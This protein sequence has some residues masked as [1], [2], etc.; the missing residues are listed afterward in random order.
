MENGL[1]SDSSPNLC[2]VSALELVLSKICHAGIFPRLAH[3]RVIFSFSANITSGK[4]RERSDSLLGS[5]ADSKGSFL[6]FMSAFVS[7]CVHPDDQSM[8]SSSSLLSHYDDQISSEPAYSI[9][10][11]VNIGKMISMVKLEHEVR[12]KYVAS[13]KRWAYVAANCFLLRDEGND[14]IIAH[15]FMLDVDDDLRQYEDLKHS[16]SYDAL[17]GIC[18]RHMIEELLERA[19]RDPSSSG[20]LFIIDL[21]NFKSVNDIM[22]HPAGDKVLIETAEA[23]RAEFRSGDVVGRLGG[24]EFLAFSK[25]LIRVDDV[26]RKACRLAKVGRRSV[27]SEDGREINLSFSIGIALYPDDGDSYE[28]LYKHADT[29]LYTSK[30]AGKGTFRL[31]NRTVEI[32]EG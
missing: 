32:P 27:F 4:I 14:D 5:A 17:T 29:A 26:V 24:D 8:L 21:D 13:G 22:G 12:V 23:L 6:D 7:E 30:D 28:T 1:A 2:A 31:F 10:F 9:R 18:N 20:A 19:F 11:R 15:V 3:G 16:A 25:G